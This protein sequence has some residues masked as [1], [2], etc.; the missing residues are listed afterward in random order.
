MSESG[1]EIVPVT[2]EANSP[3]TVKEFGTPIEVTQTL[4]RAENLWKEY[5]VPG[6]NFE[7]MK[8]EWVEEIKAGLT[9]LREGD[10]SQ[11]LITIVI[12]S[13]NEERHILQLLDSISKQDT[14]YRVQ[15]II[16][17]NNSRV[18]DDKKIIDGKEYQANRDDYTAELAKAC[19]AEVI[20]YHENVEA[21]KTKKIAPIA[22][23]RAIGISKAAGEIIISSDADAILPSTWVEALAKP[24]EDTQ[25]SVVAGDV[26]YYRG[27]FALRFINLLNRLNRRRIFYTN[28]DKNAVGWSNMAFRKADYDEFG[29]YNTQMRI[30]EDFSLLNVLKEHGKRILALRDKA[31]AYVSAR[32]FKAVSTQDALD[33]ATGKDPRASYL[34]KPKEGDPNRYF[35]HVQDAQLYPDENLDWE[36]VKS[37]EQP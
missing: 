19:G 34:T 23:A 12:P 1:L 21:G 29:G 16:V 15:V 6:G 35:R 14:K 2:V 8:N 7:K 25:V 9:R 28:P 32:R 20:E 30:G 4:N 31:T 13:H 5:R 26:D 24:F 27:P 22:S 11:P 17:D 3:K 33:E 36:E 18:K 37:P 10:P